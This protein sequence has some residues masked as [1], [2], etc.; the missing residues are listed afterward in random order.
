MPFSAT[1]IRIE[2]REGS[3]KRKI[4][5][6][7]GGITAIS[8]MTKWSLLFAIEDEKTF[9]NAVTILVFSYGF[10]VL[11]TVQVIVTGFILFGFN[12][13]F[14]LQTYSFGFEK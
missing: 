12:F 6:L 3:L 13:G 14:Q 2:L 8:V 7:Q 4:Y 9:H 5:A 1:K 11:V 10:G